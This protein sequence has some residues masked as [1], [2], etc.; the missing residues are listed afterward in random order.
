[1]KKRIL[2]IALVVALL[3]TCFA[4]T[5]A[6]LMDSE[7]QTN[8]FTTGNVYISMDEA[9]VEKNESGNLVAKKD[10]AG[11]DVR[12]AENQKYHLYP[13]MIV[14]KDPT[15]YVQGTEQA[16]V[17]AKVTVRDTTSTAAVTFGLYDLLKIEGTDLIDIHKVASGGLLKA[18]VSPVANWNGL[19]LVHETDE[20][21]IYQDAD[22]DNQTWTL[23]IFMEAP[24]AV[25]NSIQLFN[26][27]TI[28]AKWDNAEMTVINGMNI[29]VEAFA[30]QTNGFADCYTA[31]TTAF[32]DHFKFN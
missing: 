14:T 27:L 16:Y 5:Y 22:K 17:A 9:V 10:D 18:A 11:K 29:K 15:I 32:G 25:G 24:Q 28:P 26:T 6:Y 13:A 23:Y 4:G 19:D 30:T 2:T 20:C 1:M 3:A 12:T 8:T 31:M 21:V 7:A